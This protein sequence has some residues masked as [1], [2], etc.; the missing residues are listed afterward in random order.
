MG[1]AVEQRAR[2]RGTFLRR[3]AGD[4][5]TSIDWRG[6]VVEEIVKSVDAI[7]GRQ[8]ARTIESEG[9]EKLHT[10]IDARD[11]AL[12]REHVVETL[13]HDLLRLAI[14]VARTVL[15]WRHEFYVDD[16]LILRVNFPYDVARRADASAENP[17]IGRVSPTMRQLAM[18]RRVVDP[19]FDPRGYHNGHPAAAWAHG[20]HR[21]SWNG[22]SKDGINI[23]WA[24]ST[25]PAEAGMVLYPELDEVELSCDPRS[26]YLRSGYLLPKPTFAPL[27]AGEMLVFDPEVLHGTHLN[28]TDDTRVALSIRLNIKE[29]RFDPACFYA[30]EFWRRASAIEANAFGEVLHLKRED[31]LAP[32]R[33]SSPIRP[34]PRPHATVAVTP[35]SVA[36][37]MIGPS[38]LVPDGQRLVAELTDQRVL[39]VRAGGVLHA[40]PTA[41]PHN[42][43]DLSDG[44]ID[45]IALYC[46]GCGVAFDLGSGRCRSK[47]LRLRPIGVREEGGH[48]LLNGEDHASA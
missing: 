3:R 25:V 21:D 40:F 29:P 35:S 20:P 31:H 19:V 1:Q 23:W 43:V 48:I 16:Y 33:V 22:H 6:R 41:C 45:G 46:P 9:V 17:G 18:A 24:I 27:A 30:R 15:G 11:V 32:P 42:G 8:A 34:P 26:G 10:V 5:D 14:R 37:V 47:S 2:L 7:A 38:A 4:V 13:R 12:L 44:A 28:V 36:A 39:I